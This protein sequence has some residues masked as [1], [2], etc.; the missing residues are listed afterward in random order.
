ARPGRYTGVVKLGLDGTD[1]QLVV[2]VDVSI[3][4][5]PWMVLGLIVLGVILGRVAKYMN[6]TGDRLLAIGQRYDLFMWRIGALDDD[7]VRQ[8]MRDDVH[9][10]QELQRRGDYAKLTD[11]LTLAESR[12]QLALRTSHL[13]AWARDDN[14]TAEA[15]QLRALITALSRATVLD[16]FN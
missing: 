2:P 15:D 1:R 3:R 14:R 8:I 5:D 13:L 10:L 11:A 4:V 7:V 16:S 6:D 12:V 9:T